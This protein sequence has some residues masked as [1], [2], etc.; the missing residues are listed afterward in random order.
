MK[1]ITKQSRRKVRHKRVR[2]RIKGTQQRP[3]LFVFKSNK[4]IYCSLVDDINGITLI[5]F[6]DKKLSNGKDLSNKRKFSSEKNK[7][8]KNNLQSKVLEWK[9]N[10]ET[11]KKVGEELGKLGFEKGYKKIVF[12]RSGY[13]YHGKIKALAEGVRSSGLKF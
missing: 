13:K 2:A 10:I 9:N 4:H 12:D 3:R 8:S 7:T 5:S 11:A 1:T 6:S